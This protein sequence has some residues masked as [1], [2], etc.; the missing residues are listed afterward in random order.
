MYTTFKLHDG[1]RICHLDFTNV[2]DEEDALFRVNEAKAVIA[3]E[4]LQSV[5]TITNVARVTPNRTADGRD[6]SLEIEDEQG[7]KNLLRFE[8]QNQ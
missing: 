1:V 4:P 2:Q 7:E 6:E 3:K 8:T 5:Y